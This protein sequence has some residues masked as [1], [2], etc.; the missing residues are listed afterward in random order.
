VT[1][2]L[3]IEQCLPQLPSEECPPAA[4]GNKY[5]DPHPDTMQRVRELGT[6]I[7]KWNVLIKYFSFLKNIFN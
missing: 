5:R 4:D 1:S 2:I 7:P 6:L 3:L